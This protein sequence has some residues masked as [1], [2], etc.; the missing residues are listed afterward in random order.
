MTTAQLQ[1]RINELEANLAQPGH[2]PT[3]IYTRIVG[4]YRSLANWNAGKREEYNHRVTFRE[5]LA[6]QPQAS[7]SKPTSWVAFVQD[8]CPLC[9]ALKSKLPSLPFEGITFDVGQVR[10]FDAA[11]THQVM[12]TPTLILFNQHGKEMLRITSALDWKQVEAAL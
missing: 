3:E 10:G 1:T 7:I 5:K 4:Y 2:H 8:G 9:P 6:F 12:A 11:V